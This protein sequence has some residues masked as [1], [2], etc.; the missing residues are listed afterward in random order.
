MIIYVVGN[1]FYSPSAAT[2]YCDRDI[3]KEPGLN[4]Y[5]KHK[6]PYYET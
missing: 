4:A 5:L 1:I 6:P 2:C 3:A